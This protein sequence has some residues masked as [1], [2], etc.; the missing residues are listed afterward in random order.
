MHSLHLSG[1][2]RLPEAAA[3]RRGFSRTIY[4][5]AFYIADVMGY[6]LTS[7]HLVGTTKVAQ[8]AAW[9]KFENSPENTTKEPH[10]L[11][12]KN[13]TTQEKKLRTIQTMIAKQLW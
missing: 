9:K 5:F 8:S 10:R 4:N 13:L 11:A 12:I 6:G 3:Q 7:D 1:A 2:W